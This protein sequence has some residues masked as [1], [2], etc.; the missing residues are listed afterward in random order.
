MPLAEGM[1]TLPA[2]TPVLFMGW[3]CARSIKGLKKARKKFPIVAV[4]GVGITAP[5]NLGQMVDGLAEGNGIGKDTPFFYLMGGVD[6]ERLHGFYRFIM[7]KI[8]QGASQVTPD[9][10]EEKASIDAMK[11]GGSFVREKNLDP[12]LAWLSGESSAGPAVIP[13]VADGEETG[14]AAASDEEIP[15][16]DRPAQE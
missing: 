13:E 6:L 14:E 2:E 16:E 12:I 10:P 8:S 3:I 5:D 9:S 7:K 11:N 4:V 15:P 1:K